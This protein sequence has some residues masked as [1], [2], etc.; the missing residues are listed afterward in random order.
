MRRVFKSAFKGN[1]LNGFLG[2]Q[3]QHSGK[4][5]PFIYD[6]FSR[7]GVKYILKIPFK[8]RKALPAELGIGFQ[9]QIVHEVNL[10]HRSQGR[11]GRIANRPEVSRHLP[12][13]FS[14]KEMIQQLPEL[15]V[16]QGFGRGIVLGK[17]RKD[18]LVKSHQGFIQM[19]F[20]DRERMRRLFGMRDFFRTIFNDGSN[21]FVREEKDQYTKLLSKILLYIVPAFFY[22]DGFA[23]LYDPFP[24]IGFPCL[25]SAQHIH[26]VVTLRPNVLYLVLQRTI[27]LYKQKFTAAKFGKLRFIFYKFKKVLHGCERWMIS[28]P[29]TG[30][31]L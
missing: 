23:F 10:H 21:V 4:L 1:F 2:I 9:W 24:V 17:I 3:K 30:I 16:K 19:D 25:F 27:I 11:L 6:P 14:E 18:G 12:V 20:K 8:G 28:F 31:C 22:K 13:V 26:E 5:Y 7:R 15:K 29:I